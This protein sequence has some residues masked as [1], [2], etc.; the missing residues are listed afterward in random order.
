MKPYAQRKSESSPGWGE[1]AQKFFLI[2]L[3]PG[4]A[5]S[6]WLPWVP[7]LHQITDHGKHSTGPEQGQVPKLR[8]KGA[9]NLVPPHWEGEAGLAQAP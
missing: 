3:R 6:S 4:W 8:T 7:V 5:P 9:K 1:V 2:P